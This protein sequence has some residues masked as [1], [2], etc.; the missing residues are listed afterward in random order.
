MHIYLLRLYLDL[1][2]FEAFSFPLL[3]L[4]LVFMSRFYL[5]LFMVSIKKI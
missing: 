2:K 1:V 5:G 4:V 3:L